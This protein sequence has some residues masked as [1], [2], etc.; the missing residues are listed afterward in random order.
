MTRQNLPT[1]RIILLLILLF[2]WD[3]ASFA[4]LPTAV[5]RSLWPVG[6][7]AGDSFPMAINDGD[8]LDE[9]SQLTFSHP[10]ITATLQPPDT[11]VANV[12]ANPR[13]GSFDVTVA[14]DVPEGFYDAFVTGFYGSSNARRFWVTPYPM[15]TSLQA[16]QDF[17][18]AI[19]LALPQVIQTRC[20]PQATNFYLLKVDSLGVVEIDIRALRLDSKANIVV[21]IQDS[22][23]NELHRIRGSKDTDPRMKW[24]PPQSGNYF[25]LV[26][27]HLYRGGNEFFYQLQVRQG[28][29]E[30][31]SD[32]QMLA[33]PT[34]LLNDIDSPSSKPIALAGVFAGN[35][36]VPTFDFSANA[37]EIQ[38][39]EVLSASV[40]SAT[41]PQL[42]LYRVH[43]E[44]GQERLERILELDDVETV[45][46][47]VLGNRSKD[48]LVR[49]N[50]PASGRYRVLLRDLQVTSQGDWDKRFW[51]SVRSPRP[52]FKLVAVGNNPAADRTKGEQLWNPTTAR[53]KDSDRSGSRCL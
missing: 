13:W 27:D 44:N 5:L 51:L 21:S 7:A 48:P 40:G 36:H 11:S 45:P 18:S 38:I 8:F 28:D 15:T 4:Q 23:G 46:G 14:A 43:N 6:A 17:A 22:S 2:V 20:I 53:R 39:I 50:P 52:D 12:F 41:D 10:G 1:F 37:G 35:D 16:H 9:A 47:S 29:P 42:V 34:T 49:F 33:G 30:S 32:W 19:P 26:H 31:L 24:T 25:L 3:E